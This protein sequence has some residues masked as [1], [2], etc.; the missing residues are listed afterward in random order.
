LP[1]NGAGWLAKMRVGDAAAPLIEPDLQNRTPPN[2]APPAQPPDFRRHLLWDIGIL[3]IAVLLIVGLTLSWV[4]YDEYQQAQESEYRLLE[5]HA[6]N[7][8]VQVTGAL[9]KIG[10]LLNQIAKERLNIHSLQSRAFTAVLDQHRKDIPKLGTLLLTDAAGRIRAATDAAIIG[11]DVS[12]EAYFAAHLDRGPSKMFMSRPDKHLLGITAVT[13]TLPVV[14]ADRQFLGIVGVTIGF[15]FFPEVL[16]AINP[17]D[18]ASMSIIFNRDGDLLLRRE[19]PEKF[20]GYNIASVSTIF[21]EHFSYG[22]HVTR[23][24]G[25]SAHNGKTRLFLVLDVGDTGLG[26]ILSR[27]L[28][29]VLAKWYRN[30]VVYILIFLFT[31]V[32]VIFLAVIAARR[33]REIL[34]SKEELVA[35]KHQAEYANLAKSKFLAAASHDLRQPIHAQGLFLT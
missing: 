32:V 28:D 34:A 30:V 31:T 7:A 26:L 23:H 10:N 35:A 11:R 18:S 21:Q 24:V 25:P 12:Q 9:N 3:P 22:M 1:H 17:D 15:N 20:F 27:E 13:F 2:F 4:A 5:A 8:D 6:R 29:E 33:K 14:G 19:D 16:R